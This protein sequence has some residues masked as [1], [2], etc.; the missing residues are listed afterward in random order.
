[1]RAA[2]AHPRGVEVA[3][4]IKMTMDMNDGRPVRLPSSALADLG[5]GKDTRARALAALERA[6][7]VAVTREPGRAPIVR[8]DLTGDEDGDGSVERPRPRIDPGAYEPGTS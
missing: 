1:M 7:L 5:V 6:G 2:H 4:A 8:L 3:L